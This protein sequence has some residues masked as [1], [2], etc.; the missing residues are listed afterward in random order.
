MMCALAIYGFES[1]QVDWANDISGRILWTAR[2]LT[3]LSFDGAMGVSAQKP[4]LSDSGYAYSINE[5]GIVGFIVFWGLFIF[6]APADRAAW[7]LRACAATYFCLLLVISDS[8][9]SI[10]TA[11]VFW[12]ML[13]GADAQGEKR[14]QA[15]KLPRRRYDDVL[16]ARGAVAA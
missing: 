6:S 9:Y 10:K 1:M 7:R 14:A 4:F 8:P 5:I 15:S 2:L 12:F 3:S 16:A 11:A 13:G